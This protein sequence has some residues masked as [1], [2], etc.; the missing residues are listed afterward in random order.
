MGGKLLLREAY[1][2]CA[3]LLVEDWVLVLVAKVR[4]GEGKGLMMVQRRVGAGAV[5]GRKAM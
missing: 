4:C 5:D 1:R 2:E 3:C